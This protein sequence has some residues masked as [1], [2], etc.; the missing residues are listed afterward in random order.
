VAPLDGRVAV[1]TGASR[2]IGQAVA[3][4]LAEAGATVG[5]LAR[6][7]GPVAK[8]CADVGSPAFP[9]VADVSDPDQVRA[10]FAEVEQVHG[11]LDIVV[12]NAAVASPHLIEE[13]GDDEL[14]AQVATNVLGPLY[15]VRSAVPLLR[16]SDDAHIVNIS[17]DSAADPYPYLTLYAGTKSALETMSRGLVHELKPDG[18]RVTALRVGRTETGFK[19][20]WDPARLE[21]A[22]AAWEQAGFTTRVS[23]EVAQSPEQVASAVL[24]VCTRAPGTMVDVLH[25]RAFSP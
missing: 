15:V 18:I 11:R 24:F 20:G 1:V 19:D 3:K 22:L 23:G 2:G 5:L 17:S 6:S 13:A 16:C 4:V 7:A 21:R 12:N 14:L 25:V 9:L 8:A 10:A